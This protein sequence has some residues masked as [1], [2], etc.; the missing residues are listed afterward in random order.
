MLELLLPVG[1]S[2]YTFQ[3]LSYSIDV[4]FGLQKAENVEKAESLVG[5]DQLFMDQTWTTE[6][7]AERGRKTIAKGVAAAMKI[8]YGDE[9]RDAGY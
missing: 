3:T 2:F 5:E 4:Y 6:H 8:W 9:Y 1:I 7:Y